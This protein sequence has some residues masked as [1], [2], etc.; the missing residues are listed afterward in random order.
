VA[1]REGVDRKTRLA[2]RIS[3]NLRRLPCASERQLCGDPDEC[4][5]R[6]VLS[7]LW[8]LLRVVCTL[9]RAGPSDGIVSSHGIAVQ[10]LYRVWVRSE[11]S[12]VRNAA[13]LKQAVPGAAAFQVETYVFI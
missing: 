9:K 1:F 2:L 3:P 11:A 5:S 6:P 7:F 13:I 10:T 12:L 4:R 8:R